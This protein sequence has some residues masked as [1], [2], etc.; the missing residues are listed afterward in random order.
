MA[1]IV[2]AQG[3]ILI[4]GIILPLQPLLMGMALQNRSGLVQQGTPYGYSLAMIQG[5][6]GGKPLHTRATQQ[7]QQQGLGLI[8]AVVGGNHGGTVPVG[9]SK[10]GLVSRLPGPG[11]NALAGLHPHRDYLTGQPH[12]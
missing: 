2:T 10:Q 12:G 3:L 11:F 9:I 1:Q 4:A 8:I 5:T 6:H 7:A